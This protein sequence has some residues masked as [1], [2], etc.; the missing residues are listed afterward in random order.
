MELYGHTFLEPRE[1]VEGQ[2]GKF[3]GLDEYIGKQL[4][5]CA[6]KDLKAFP[7]LR[8]TIVHEMGNKAR[9]VTP[10]PYWIQVLEAPF[11]HTIVQAMRFHP[12][13]WSS[14]SKQDQCWEAMRILTKVKTLYCRDGSH[15]LTLSSD[16]KNA[17]NV[18]RYGLSRALI[19]GFCTG[20]GLIDR[21]NTEYY[22]IVL[23]LIGPRLIEFP[24]HETILTKRCVPM[25]EPLA[26]PCLTLLGLAVEELAFLKYEKRLDL[27]SSDEPDP[28]RD[29]RAFHLG[30]DDHL[31]YGPRGYLDLIT[32]CHIDSGSQVGL[33][34]HGISAT[35]VKYTEKLVFVKN[36]KYHVPFK[37]LNNP[38]T[39]STNI[40]V[41]SIK[42]RLLER[43][44]SAMMSKDDKN[45]AIGKSNNLIRSIEYM[46]HSGFPD[47]MLEMIHDLFIKR[48]GPFLPSQYLR[49]KVFALAHLPI[50][51]GGYGLGR[52]RDLLYWLS[53]SP[54]PHQLLIGKLL[55]GAD[56]RQEFHLI[57]RLNSNPSKRGVAELREYTLSLVDKLS[58]TKLRTL[59]YGEIKDLAP[60]EDFRMCYS[61]ATA[62]GVYTLKDF[63]DIVTRGT[64]FQSLL[65]GTRVKEFNSFPLWVT[66]R[67]IWDTLME[68]VQ[69]FDIPDWENLTP[70]VIISAIYGMDKVT[71][72]DGQQ[73]IVF[74]SPEDAFFREYTLED[75]LKFGA[76]H[77]SIGLRSL[78]LR[79]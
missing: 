23:D 60:G 36:M 41:D 38:L 73:T 32:Q 15:C 69:G 12:S 7:T 50:S 45:V 79:H 58:D 10:A 68:G 22:S 11:A 78:G 77:L 49:P 46:G 66:Y 56:C 3:W 8:T 76:P 44:Q 25:A 16:L 70:Q 24:D 75:A 2:P 18:Q 30:G 1:A 29:W 74:R 34:K 47:Y 55:T 17:T 9:V 72:I 33:G 59:S 28:Y 26:K 31:A 53:K 71:F 67:Q 27:L 57:R 14:F 61:L 5:Y 6:W 62:K 65:L 13:V 37:E 35:L 39:Y 4:L 20:Y 52:S 21:S 51:L 40:F 64:I 42:I 48:M 63:G 19:D 43:G 54:L